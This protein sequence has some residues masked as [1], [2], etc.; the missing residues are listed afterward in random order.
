M[1]TLTVATLVDRV[2]AWRVALRFAA[3]R[4]WLS[5]H[6]PRGLRSDGWASNK[7]SPYGLVSMVG[8]SY[9][10]PASRAWQ[11]ADLELSAALAGPHSTVIRADAVIVWLDPQPIPSSPGADPIRVTVAGGCPQSDRGVTGVTNP[12]A[13][14]TGRLLPPG[15]PT[16]GLRCRYDGLNGHPWRLV[17]AAR[18]TAAQARRAARSMAR[19]SLSH[20]DGGIPGSCPFDDLSYEVLALTYPGRGDVDLWVKLNGCIEISNGYIIANGF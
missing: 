1:G 7:D 9:A 20:T 2:V 10:G 3:V 18:L 8:T 5:A 12:G 14:L 4:A 15:Q 17:G 13:K 6:P 11:S 19:L 16:A